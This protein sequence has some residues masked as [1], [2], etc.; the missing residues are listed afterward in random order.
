MV[1]LVAV[2]C[3]AKNDVYKCE[4]ATDAADE[5]KP[6][7]KITCTALKHDINLS[8]FKVS[9]S[10]TRKE[11]RKGKYRTKIRNIGRWSILDG[12][13]MKIKKGKTKTFNGAA[14]LS[15]SSGSKIRMSI[16]AKIKY[17]K[18]D[19]P[20]K[21]GLLDGWKESMSISSRI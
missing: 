20:K 17:P 11:L 16:T 4:L 12:K 7:Y 21:E 3:G 6:T 5:Y 9:L 18:G 19:G 8:D 10:S 2:N 13:G 15:R 14:T 1:L